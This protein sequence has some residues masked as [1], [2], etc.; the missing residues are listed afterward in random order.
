MKSFS[1][2]VAESVAKEIVCVF[3]RFNPPTVAHEKM[4]DEAA[5]IAT[6]KQYRIYVS[7]AEDSKNNPIC[8][9]EKV[10]Y[11]RKMFPRFARSVMNDSD[12]T[13][14]L[15]ICAKLYEQG[16]TKVTL[17]VGSDKLAEVTALMNHYNGRVLNEGS[18]FQFEHGV[19]IVS[20]GDIDP[21]TTASLKL[22][23][24]AIANNLEV[25][26]KGLPAAFTETTELFNSVRAGLG[27]KESKTFRKHIQL[28]SVSERRE[29]YIKGEIF[30]VGDDVVLTESNEV[31]KICLR[32]A[33][34]LVVSM[35]DGRKVRRWLNGVE[36]VEK[37][38]TDVLELESAPI[39][40]YS[41]SNGAG[42]S[43][44]KIRQITQKQ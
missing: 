5:K 23:E 33:N 34:Y 28:E 15:Q 9:T 25:F 38:A 21:D 26:S 13:T 18:S 42:K 27:L 12:V 43:V 36:L 40:E 3:G 30:N 7:K 29:A 44:S 16:F 37:I 6:G 17:V 2:F 39:I 20:F 35:G 32:G 41:P 4:L 1:Q 8:F 11:V 31:G 10:K 14:H 22:R 19:K 24:S